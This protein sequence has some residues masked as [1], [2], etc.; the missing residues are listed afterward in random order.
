MNHLDDALQWN[1][2]VLFV[3]G[4]VEFMMFAGVAVSREISG[5]AN[6]DRSPIFSGE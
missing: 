4:V 3:D 2:M 1:L 6:Y 5:S